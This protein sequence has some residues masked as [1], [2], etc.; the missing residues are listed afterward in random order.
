MPQ[1]E[2]PGRKNTARVNTAEGAWALW[3]RQVGPGI[4]AALDRMLPPSTEPPPSVHRAMRYSVFSGGKRIRPA[5]AALGF[6]MGG[7]KGDGGYQL[8]AAIELIHTF[9]LIHDDLPCMDDDDFRRGRLSSH[10]KFG[11]AIAVL[12][13][14]AL[15]VLA[16]DALAALPAPPER[17][18]RVLREITRAVGTFGVIGGQVVDIESEGK[19]ISPKRLLW[20]HERKTGALLRCSL[21][22]GGILAGMRPAGIARLAR[23]GSAF[24]LLFQI[25][26]DLLDVLGSY[27][28]LG[29]RRG[30]DRV[31]GKATYPSILGL[32]RTRQRLRE[33][34]EQ[35][36]AA[37]PAD[38]G[39][40]EILT[41]LIGVVV[42][43]LPAEWLESSGARKAEERP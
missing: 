42:G 43:R 6:S 30:R 40:G 26:D 17:R 14:D 19:Q 39:P 2:R 11:E 34:V 20:M 31:R 18:L 23:F 24:G 21:T 4:E 7:G 5:L 28:A 16:F 10:R 8:G 25:V 12:A 13:G 36:L 9:S 35:S 1:G 37:I 22:S 33:A 3:W 15:H 41:D 38:G 27:R 32:E 29:R